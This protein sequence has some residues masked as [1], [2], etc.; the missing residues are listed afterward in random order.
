MS[1]GAGVIYMAGAEHI[2]GSGQPYLSKKA[3]PNTTIL[4]MR[5]L[6][7]CLATVEQGYGY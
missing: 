6:T 2:P 1:E 3:M 7:Q 5:V 4:D